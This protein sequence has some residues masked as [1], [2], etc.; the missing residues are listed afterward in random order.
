LVLSLAALVRTAAAQTQPTGPE[1]WTPRSARVVV[2]AE[3]L[4]GFHAYS[5]TNEPEQGDST[6]IAG[7][8]LSLLYGQS[9][10][11]SEDDQVN[12]YAV[13]RIGVDG[14]IAGRFTLGGNL[15]FGATLGEIDNG[16]SKRSLPSVGGFAV[17]ARL[18][19]LVV[20]SA[21]VSIWL[22]A[23][24]EFFSSSYDDSGARVEYRTKLL[25]LTL[26]PQVVITPVPHAAILVGPLVNLGVW[27]SFER[28]QSTSSEESELRFSNFGVTAGLALLF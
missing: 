18:G 8:L 13:P 25:A 21:T 11:N 22:R 20:P 2:S 4:F 9:V 28:A 24:P 23:G 12:P 15:G 26:D 6:E 10:I 5:S 1:P 7:V 19:Y 3:R 17:Y 14:V 27:G 16:S